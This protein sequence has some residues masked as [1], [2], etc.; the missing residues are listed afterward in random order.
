[1]S[2]GGGGCSPEGEGVVPHEGLA[3][4]DQEGALFGPALAVL[5]Q[6]LLRH[7]AAVAASSQLPVEPALGAVLLVVVAFLRNNGDGEDEP[8]SPD[9]LVLVV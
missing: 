7:L 6:E 1:M 5:L 9:P 3:L 4:P 2:G 8:S